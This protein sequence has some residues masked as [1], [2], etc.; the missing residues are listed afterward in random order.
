MFDDHESERVDATLSSDLVTMYLADIG[1]HPL[2]TRDDEIRLDAAVKAGA[3]A[4]ARLGSGERLSPAEKRRLRRQ[5]A[6]GEHARR[7]FINSNLRLVV[8]IAKKYGRSGVPLLDLI[9]D[10]NLG[11]MHAVEKFDATKGFK[12][13]TY[14][15]WW[16]RQAISRGI[17][18]HSR[19]IRLSQDFD[20]QWIAIRRAQAVLVS[21][22]GRDPSMAEIAEVVAMTPERVRAVLT[23]PVVSSSLDSALEP[24]ESDGTLIDVLPDV[25]TRVEAE[26]V[27]M[28]TSAEVREALDAL[29]HRER[30]VVTM[31]FGLDGSEPMTRVRVAEALGESV[32]DL[33]LVER[34]ALK[35]LRVLLDHSLLVAV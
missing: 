31:R 22:L 35:R 4:R 18:H 26:A 24:G 16:I 30:R 2:L 1:R 12:F 6:D 7:V 9:Q 25:D 27:A 14:A 20:V 34:N 17:S 5:V 19:T 8:S 15:T 11:L 23:A 32:E 28:M 33:R 29:G 10:G 21:E 13:S 3:E